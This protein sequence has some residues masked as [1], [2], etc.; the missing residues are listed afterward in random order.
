MWPFFDSYNRYD[1][2]KTRNRT[3]WE[4]HDWRVKTLESII[5]GGGSFLAFCSRACERTFSCTTA[6]N[7][8]WAIR[9]EGSALP[10]AV[11]HTMAC[12]KL[13]GPTKWS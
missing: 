3:P 7:R 6:S 5:V 1:M 11:R 8:A 2:Q 13:S 9:G 12:V 4:S 10:D